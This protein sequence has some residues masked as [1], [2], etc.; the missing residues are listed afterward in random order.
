MGRCPLLV[1]TAA[2]NALQ[3]RS[4]VGQAILATTVGYPKSQFHRLAVLP[5]IRLGSLTL[6][7]FAQNRQK[8]DTKPAESI[9]STDSAIGLVDISKRCDK[10][11]SFNNEP[12]LMV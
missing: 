5:L 1:S 4:I 10:A 2:S 12:H 3:I 9:R 11:L 7:V 8:E 6:D